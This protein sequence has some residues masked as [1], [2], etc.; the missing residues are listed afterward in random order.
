MIPAEFQR[1]VM[2]DVIT[3]FTHCIYVSA[4]TTFL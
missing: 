3:A 1:L 2:A 4:R